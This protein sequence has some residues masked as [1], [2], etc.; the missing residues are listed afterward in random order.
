MDSQLKPILVHFK[1]KVCYEW[2]V[3]KELPVYLLAI[4]KFMKLN[5]ADI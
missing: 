2:F 5:A 3:A 4:Y 1:E